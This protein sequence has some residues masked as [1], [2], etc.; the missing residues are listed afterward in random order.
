[1]KA[2]NSTTTRGDKT[3]VSMATAYSLGVFND[4]FFKQAALLLAISAGLTHL[5]GTA[6]I[7]FALPF[8]LCSAYAGWLADRFPKKNIVVNGKILELVA[9]LFGAVGIL[10]TNWS[11]IIAMIFLM[12]LQSAIFGPALNG[13]IPEHFATHKITRVNG[14]LKMATTIAI[15]VGMACAGIALDLQSP[16]FGT[17]LGQALIACTVVLVSMTGV[18]ASLGIKKYQ[19]AAPDKPFPWAGPFHSLRDFATLRKDPLLLLAVVSDAFFYFLAALVVLIINTY[20]ID[21]L[22]LSQT[23]T[24]LMS[25]ALMVGVAIG[26][27]FSSKVTTTDNWTKVLIPGTLGMG[28][29][30]IAAALTINLSEAYRV[31]AL[32]ASFIITG[33]CGGFFLIP[34]TSF[35]QVRPKESDK[36]QVIA[37]VGFCSFIGI[38]LAGQI[39]T[40]MDAVIL[41]GTMFILTGLISLCA[42]ATIAISLRWGKSI[43]QGIIHKTV[44]TMLCLRYDIT[45]TGLNN[46]NKTNTEGILFL[47]NH[48]AWVDPV[49][50]MTILYDKFQPRPLADYDETDKFYIRPLMTLINAIRIPKLTKNGRGSKDEVTGGIKTVATSL[51]QGDNII[52]YPA[53]QL[54]RSMFEK[55][56]AK[57]AVHT[58]LTQNPQQRVVLVRTSGL[59]GSSFSWAKGSPRLSKNWKN[60][61]AYVLTNLLFFCPRRKVTVE[62]AEPIDLPRQ[63]DRITLNRTLEKFYNAKPQPNQH[64]PYFWW[65]GSNPESRPDPEGPTVERDLSNVPESVQEQVMKHIK[66]INEISTINVQDK[67]AQDIGMDSL[68][69]MELVAWIEQEF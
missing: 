68:S 4:N 19:A 37:V 65:Q 32:F 26:A 11:C 61:L 9:M 1:M 23:M 45:V 43:V 57:S 49:I 60:Y 5:Q 63:A 34:I 58:I 47:P 25:V 46:L 13:S 30:L 20:G 17:T 56:G 55:L 15:L 12:G 59:W 2:T 21:Q 18:I 35:I 7:V 48:P 3:F 24:S 52:L 27:V 53:G 29:G 42:A 22:G 64:V 54:Y 31:Y 66:K 67:L 69:M 41:P 28:I 39:Y 50:L 16:A 40:L 36:G 44:K 6:T 33:F 38:L 51:R 62:F 10:F 14:S 8:I